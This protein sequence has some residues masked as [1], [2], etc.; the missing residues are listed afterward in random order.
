MRP[1]SLLVA[2]ETLALAAPAPS[3]EALRSTSRLR[4]LR[5]CDASM[6]SN[7]ITGASCTGWPHCLA[8]LSPCRRPVWQHCME[9]AQ[10][11]PGQSV[12]RA[13]Q[14]PE[15]ACVRMQGLSCRR[16]RSWCT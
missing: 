4:M 15:R 11:P 9:A 6:L 1:R 5:L 10:L 16:C 2:Q 7:R 8:L 3:L 14:S 12:C 13:A